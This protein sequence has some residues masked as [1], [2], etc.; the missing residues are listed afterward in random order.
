MSAGD[1]NP[2]V[3][4]SCGQHDIAGDGPLEPCHFCGRLT[5]SRPV[6]DWSLGRMYWPIC[7]ACVDG[8]PYGDWFVPVRLAPDEML[9]RAMTLGVPAQGVAQA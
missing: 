1:R 3:R 4:C 6:I 7:H 8:V 9:A 5:S 2:P